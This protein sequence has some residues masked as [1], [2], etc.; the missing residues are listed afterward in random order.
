MPQRGKKRAH[1]P[2]IEPYK[3]NHEHPTPTRAKLQGA[4]E[5]LEARGLLKKNANTPIPLELPTKHDVYQYFQVPDRTGSRILNED[6]PTEQDGEISR[7][8]LHQGT[9][10]KRGKKRAMVRRS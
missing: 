3:R 7:R 1:S 4:I 2:N 5:F 9:E 10:E 6:N 8:G